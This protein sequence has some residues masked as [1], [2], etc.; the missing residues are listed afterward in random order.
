MIVEQG[1]YFALARIY[2][3]SFGTFVDFG[4]VVEEKEA[5]VEHAYSPPDLRSC[6]NGGQQPRV[7]SH[8]KQ[9][10]FQGFAV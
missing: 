7:L 8:S 3:K 4:V 5:H 6:W 2:I 9:D 1:A 10:C